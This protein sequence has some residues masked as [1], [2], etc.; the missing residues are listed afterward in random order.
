[1]LGGSNAGVESMAKAH[2]DMQKVAA[3]LWAVSVAMA[4]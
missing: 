3:S 2:R 1:M 4:F